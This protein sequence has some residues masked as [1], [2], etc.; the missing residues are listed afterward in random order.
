MFKYIG[1]FSK[2]EKLVIENN[3]KLK[4]IKEGEEILILGDIR[5]VARK[6]KDYIEFKKINKV[7]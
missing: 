3:E 6:E 5:C 1:N 7:Y 4:Q 2:E